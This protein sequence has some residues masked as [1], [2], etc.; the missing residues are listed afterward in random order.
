MPQRCLNAAGWTDETDLGRLGRGAAALVVCNLDQSRVAWLFGNLPAY[1]KHLTLSENDLRSV[2]GCDTGS[3]SSLTLRNNRLK[4][5][6]GLVTRAALERLDLSYNRLAGLEL[7]TKSLR[8]LNLVGNELASLAGLV[9][10]DALRELNAG[11]NRISRLALDTRSIERLVL[12]NNRIATLADLVVGDHLEFLDVTGNPL[13]AVVRVSGLE[14]AWDG[15]SVDA[16]YH[17][18]PAAAREPCLVCRRARGTHRY[19]GCACPVRACRPCAEEMIRAGHT[20]CA[21]CRALAQ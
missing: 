7:D 6:D 8:S 2:A 17:P 4:S 12:Y 11:G 20:A 3:L 13:L 9:V 14:V 21:Y 16:L 5:L 18:D 19:A 10:R 1:V 15:V